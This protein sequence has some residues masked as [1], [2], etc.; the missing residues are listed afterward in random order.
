[1]HLLHVEH[2][3]MR[4]C[5]VFEL[6]AHAARPRCQRDV[7]VLERSYGKEALPRDRPCQALHC[8]P[9]PLLH[10]A[11]IAILMTVFFATFI[12]GFVEMFV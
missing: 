5:E 8:W 7:R 11:L 9:R 10:A 12:A 2:C 4:A 3:Q 6:V 1:M